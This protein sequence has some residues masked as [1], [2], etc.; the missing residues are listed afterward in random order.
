LGF[1]TG[2][3]AKRIVVGPALR[4]DLE[5]T[6]HRVLTSS[7]FGGLTA[8]IQSPAEGLWT[9]NGN[10]TGRDD[11]VMLEVMVKGVE[12][13][14]WETYRDRLQELLRQESIVVRV[15]PIERI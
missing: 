11:I 9:G 5:E 10:H 7:H 3:A 2:A 8:F 15:L 13:G 12:R 4:F 1:D 14:W 6:L